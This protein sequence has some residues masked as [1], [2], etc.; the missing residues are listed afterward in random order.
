MKQAKKDIAK[1]LR[2]LAEFIVS[3]ATA[4]LEKLDD[5]SVKLSKEESTFQDMLDKIP[6]N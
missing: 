2:D 3:E 6:F 5:E 1:Y 4:T